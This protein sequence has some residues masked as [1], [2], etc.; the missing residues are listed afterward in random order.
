M[1]FVDT[2]AFFALFD[3][4]D[5]NHARGL[6]CWFDL[7]DRG[8]PLFT[9]NYVL[10]ES[11][12]LAQR[13]LGLDAVR[14]L[15]EDLIPAVETRWVDPATHAVAMAVLLTANRR[16]LSLVDCSSFSMMRLAGSR[17]AFA[18]DQHFTDEGFGFPA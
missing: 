7:L 18:F 6:K 17:I 1:I 9:S 13:R 10:V 11:C 8:T 15:H 3:R 16:K 2:S 12:A 14:S 4:D 5:H